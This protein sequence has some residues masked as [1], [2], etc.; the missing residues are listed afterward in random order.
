MSTVRPLPPYCQVPGRVPNS[1]PHTNCHLHTTNIRDQIQGLMKMGQYFCYLWP[2]YA[3]TTKPFIIYNNLVAN[4]GSCNRHL[5]LKQCSS[6][7]QSIHPI[8]CSNRLFKQIQSVCESEIHIFS[9]T[10]V[11]I[12]RGNLCHLIG[13]YTKHLTGYSMNIVRVP[14]E[15]SMIQ[16]CLQAC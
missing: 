4:I 9:S 13:G 6:F 3:P 2:T 16:Y 5:V 15:D 7:S 1:E 10:E 11:Q 8:I 12:S 14:I